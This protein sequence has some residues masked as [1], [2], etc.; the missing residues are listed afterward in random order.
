MLDV[1]QD[2]HHI[3][4]AQMSGNGSLS[5]QCKDSHYFGNIKVMFGSFG[6]IADFYYIV[7]P[8]C[9]L[10]LSC[11]LFLIKHVDHRIAVGNRERDLE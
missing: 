9:Y 8:K 11:W 4:F 6:A 7:F 3:I 1:Y 2:L 5:I 10:F